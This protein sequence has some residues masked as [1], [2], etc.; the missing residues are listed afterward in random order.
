RQIGRGERYPALG[1]HWLLGLVRLAQDDAD[2]ALHEFDREGRLA[3]P[4]RLYGREYAMNAAHG[5]GLSLL[6]LQRPEEAIEAFQ[7]ALALYP[8]HAQSSL[9]L[10]LAFRATGS[11]ALADATFAGVHRTRA[12]L[13]EVRPIEAA[14]VRA[15]LLAALCKDDE[16]VAVLG[17]LV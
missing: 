7:H 11:S 15:Q 17:Q 5:C 3:E 2:E 12:S 1:L 4:N 13:T 9:G 6:H 14:L 16:A 8:N 10:A